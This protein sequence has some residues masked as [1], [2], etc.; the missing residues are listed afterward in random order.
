ME[1]CIGRVLK[2]RGLKGELVVYFLITKHN[3][4]EGD[5]LLFDKMG[6]VFGPYEVEYIKFYKYLREKSLYLLK[7]K[8]INSIEDS[9]LLKGSFIIKDFEKLPD[10]IFFKTNIIGCSVLL[11]DKEI[12]IGKVKDIIRVKEDYNILL[13]TTRKSKEE[14]FIPFTKEVISKIELQKKYIFVDSLEGFL[15]EYI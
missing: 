10:S 11:K 3:S 12:I 9:L 8:E 7:L 15:E 1:V 14:I 13:V 5:F 4:K 6:E 2:P